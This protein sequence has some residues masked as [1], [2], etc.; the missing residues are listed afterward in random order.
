MADQSP[1]MQVKMFKYLIGGGGGAEGRQIY[2]TMKFQTEEKKRPVDELFVAFDEYCNPKKNETVERYKF[3]LRNQEL[4]ETFDKFVTELKVLAASCN[5]GELEESLLRDRV[6]C[7]ILDSSLRE[8]LLREA[9]SDLPKCLQ[10]CRAAELSQ[11]RVQNL[12]K[13]EAVYKFR[14]A[15]NRKKVVPLNQYSMCRYCGRNHEFKGLCVAPPC[16]SDFHWLNL[17]MG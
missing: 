13:V 11:S 7:G 17:T 16:K 6:V 15:R 2:A 1:E 12:E 5:F 3:F 4:G 9:S 14:D 8:R 10:I